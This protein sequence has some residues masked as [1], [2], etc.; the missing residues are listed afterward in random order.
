M[1]RAIERPARR[2]ID[3][4]TNVTPRPATTFPLRLAAALYGG[5]NRR[6]VGQAQI[7]PKPGEG[8]SE[9]YV[10]LRVQPPVIDP[11]D[12]RRKGQ[13]DEAGQHLEPRILHPQM[14][15]KGASHQEGD[16]QTA[17]DGE[18]LPLNADEQE[19][20]ERQLQNAH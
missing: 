19:Q 11:R 15:D 12:D 1:R 18:R 16:A 20:R 3:A 14:Y 7:G 9:I 2:G 13:Q 8:R 10:G 6:I 4:T 5:G 17:G